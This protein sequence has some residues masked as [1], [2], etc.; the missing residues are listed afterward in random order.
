MSAG[1]DK[2]SRGETQ[3]FRIG[4]MGDYPDAENFLQLFYGPNQ[5][6]GPNRSN[7]RNPAFDALYR[8][9]LA[10]DTPGRLSRY[11]DMQEIIRQ[12]CP[13][14]FIHF[15]RAYSLSHRHVID[16]QPHDFPYGMEKY[17]RHA[18]G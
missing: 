11:R 2:V 12:D 1:H 16:F 17:L 18:R 14:I 4:W 7:Y 9:A 15:A 8:E 6:P 3:L 13:W 5:S 10:A